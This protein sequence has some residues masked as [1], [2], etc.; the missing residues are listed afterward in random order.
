[1]LPSNLSPVLARLCPPSHNSSQVPAKTPYLSCPKRAIIK[2]N[3]YI[4]LVVDILAAS[5]FQHVHPHQPLF[6]PRT[7]RSWQARL[8]DHDLDDITACICLCV[9]GL[10]AAS[11]AQGGHPKAPET[12]GLEYFQPALKMLVREVLWEFRPSISMCQ[13]LLLASS[14]FA[15][16]G[17][18]RKSS[19]S[20]CLQLN[21]HTGQCCF[22]LS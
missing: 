5:Y 2:T 14:Y 11:S 19:L 7:F 22:K 18:P 3:T 17:R 6:T 20:N 21:D 13:A 10:G 9:Y 16:L 8:L 1:M 15:H 4:T 12:L